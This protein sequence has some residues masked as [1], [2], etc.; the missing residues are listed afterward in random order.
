MKSENTLTL[1]GPKTPGSGWA[2]ALNSAGYVMQ[3][4]HY[5]PK[6]ERGSVCASRLRRHKLPVPAG[7]LPKDVRKCKGCQDW[8]EGHPDGGVRYTNTH[9]NRRSR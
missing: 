5:Y 9:H 4:Y 2:Q 1:A 8:V 3:S 6:D 7:Q